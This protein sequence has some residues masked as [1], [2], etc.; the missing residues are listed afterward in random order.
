MYIATSVG[1]GASTA[2]A[3]QL[4]FHLQ[5][6]QLPEQG[7][8]L[9]C[10]FVDS[11]DHVWYG[12]EDG[13]FCFDFRKGIEPKHYSTAQGLTDNGVASITEDNK[14]KIWLGTNSG[15]NMLNPKDGSIIRF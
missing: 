7:Q 9:H 11:K 4:G 13:A 2:E 5:G 6:H 10:V 15:L 1:L 14:G 12:T 3:K 8:L